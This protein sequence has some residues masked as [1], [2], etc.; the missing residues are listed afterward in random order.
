MDNTTE[1][2]NTQSQTSDNN[3]QASQ[4]TILQSKK[5]RVHHNGFNNRTFSDLEAECLAHMSSNDINYQGPLKETRPGIPFRFSVDTKKREKNEFYFCSKWEFKDRAYLRCTYGTW[6]G[7]LT[8]YTYKS[9]EKCDFKYL[10]PEDHKQFKADEARREREHIEAKNKETAKRLNGA[11]SK[12]KKAKD[13][14]SH[15][16]HTAYLDGKNAKPIGLKYSRDYEG[17]HVLVIPIR[18]SQDE[19]QSV[20]YIKANGEKKIH[21]LKTGNY[22]LLGKINDDVTIFVAEGYATAYS[23][24]EATGSP[25]VVAFDCGNLD[26]VI[27]NLRTKY[28]YHSMIIAA[29]DDR[30]TKDNPGRTHAER[31]AQKYKCSVI[32]PKFPEGFIL[33]NGKPATDFNDLRCHFGLDEVKKQV[34]TSN[35]ENQTKTR[36][37][38]FK[39]YSFTDLLRIPPKKWLLNKVFGKGDLGMIYGP[40]GCGKT[41]IVIDMII[42]LCVGTIWANRFKVERSLNVAYCAGEGISGLPSRFKAAAKHHGVISLCNFTFYKT[43][44]Q[45]YLDANSNAPDTNQEVSTIK[46]FC[47]EWKARQSKPLDVLVI[48]T[49]HTATI[50]ADE[51]SAKDMGKV[52]Q[53]CRSVADDLDCAVILVHHTNKTGSAERGSSSLRGAMDFM[54][55]IKNPLDTQ[56][57]AILSCSKLKDGEQWQDQS[58]QL[59]SVEDCDNVCIAWGDDINQTTPSRSKAMD[60]LT[61]KKEMERYPGKKFTCKVLAQSIEQRDVYTRKL[62][63]E[64]YKA[65]ECKKELADLS[66]RLSSKNPWVYWI[67]SS[68]QKAN[69]T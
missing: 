64:L 58:F 59:C 42:T 4:K 48:D 62:L 24:H 6:T 27:D 38:I 5:Q 21:G 40:P 47:D 50:T 18:N 7:G 33:S 17:N 20:Q 32:L 15:I 11:K 53:A 46:L 30:G 8:D 13:Q 3:S 52:L 36:D 43:I 49:L 9:Y 68:I 28:P 65:Q 37:P 29:D 60:K 56:K 45:L 14:P 69:S 25:V 22:H 57:K 39:P 16:D 34:V 12:W 41:F 44:P 19:I 63:N 51:N 10:S 61:L 23:V 54:L 55:E 66:R 2:Q 35:P 31:A 67:E 26:S 1:S